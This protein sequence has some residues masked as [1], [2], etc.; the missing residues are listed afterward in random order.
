MKLLKIIILGLGALAASSAFVSCTREVP[1]VATV[2]P[3]T[4]GSATVQI[5]SAT[6]RAARNYIYV[7]GAPVSGVAIGIGSI[8]PA[9]AYAFKV[10]PGAHTFL[11]K[12]TLPATTQV[13]LTFSQALDSGKSYTIFTYDT[14]TNVKQS[15]IV[16]T[17]EIATDTTARLRFAN[18]IYNTTAVPAVDVYSFRKGTSAAVFT[19]VATLQVTPF[20]PYQTGISDTL[21][22]YATGT[23]APLIVKQV[24]PNLTP[25]RSYTATYN[26][27]FKGTKSI[28]TFA[29]Y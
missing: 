4:G 28:S 7:D 15:T 21:Y 25:G 12:D 14:I 22:V 11:I 23:T 26:G 5:F 3:G 17:I 8:F 20:I 13:P 10:S 19:N 2:Q 16:N 18:F 29:T 9:T 27:S 1:L 24:V 6:V